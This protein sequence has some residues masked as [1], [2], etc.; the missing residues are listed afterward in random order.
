MKKKTKR[1][2]TYK[3][4]TLSQLIKR[5]QLWEEDGYGDEAVCIVLSGKHR[6]N[7]FGPANA[8]RYPPVGFK[9]VGIAICA[10]D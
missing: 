4:F 8:T 5:L 3:P 7:G 6:E 2:P 1:T 10:D 9:P